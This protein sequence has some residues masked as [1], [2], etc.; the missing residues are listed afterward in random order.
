MMNFTAG[1]HV[2]GTFKNVPFTGVVLKT[3]LACPLAHSTAY[4]HELITIIADNPIDTFCGRPVNDFVF[5]PSDKHVV[6]EIS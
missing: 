2:H 6:I 3:R 1:Q 5:T 4:D